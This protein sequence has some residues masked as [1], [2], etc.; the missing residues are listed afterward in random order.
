MNVLL[1]TSVVSEAM[2]ARPAAEVLAWI[3]AQPEAAIHLSAATIA[4]ID[5]GI[6][7]LPDGYK[8]VSLQTWRD[9]VVALSR[10]RILP[11]DLTVASAWGKLRG[12]AEAARRTMSL[13]DAL[14]A[15]TAEVYDLMLVTRN[16][17]DFEVWGGP[18]FN[19][20]PA[21]DT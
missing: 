2:A 1:D 18:V 3:R 8:R 20:W 21:R 10:R 16:I 14:I 6:S 13:I 5:F 11:V 19:P 4:E 7:R 15:A 12:K 9:N 17:K